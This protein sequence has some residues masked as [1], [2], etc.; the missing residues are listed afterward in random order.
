MWLAYLG[1]EPYVRRF[2]ADALI[3]WSRLVAGNWRDPRVG[4]DVMIGVAVG[5]A[6]TVVFAVHNLLPPLFGQPEPM[7]VAAGSERADLGP[8]RLR[9]ECCSN[10]R[11]P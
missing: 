6:M 4:R 2:S 7:P 3:G 9:A 5:V 1:V 11:T 10:C 8:L